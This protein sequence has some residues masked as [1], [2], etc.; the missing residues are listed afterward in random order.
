MTVILVDP[1]RP[2]L[3]PVEAVAMLGG[4]LQYTEEMPIRVPW[5][6]PSARPVYTGA[7]APVLL[8]SDR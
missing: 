7:D 4:D 2:Y 6:L 5:S 8:S 1:R 3:V